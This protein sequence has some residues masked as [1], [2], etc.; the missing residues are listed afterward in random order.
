MKLDDML[1]KALSDF[2]EIAPIKS[3]RAS[4]VKCYR[5]IQLVEGVSLKLIIGI[6]SYFPYSLPHFFIEEYDSL[7][8]ML[9]HVETDGYVCFLEKDNILLDYENPEGIF[10]ESLDK[11][12]Q[13]LSASIQ[14][15]NKDEIRSEFISYWTLQP[16][17]LP[18][19]SFIEPSMSIKEIEGAFHPNSYLFY[20]NTAENIN[21]IEAIFGK[22]P[23]EQK[24]KVTYIPLRQNNNIYPPD[25][26]RGWS[27]RE[28][29]KIILGNLS[30][31]NRKLFNKYKSKPLKNPAIILIISIPITENNIVFIGVKLETDNRKKLYKNPLHKNVDNYKLTPIVIERY[32]DDYLIE[33]TSSDYS[34]KNKKVAIVGQGSL[35]S[36]VTMELARLGVRNLHLIDNDI[37]SID[38]IN[39]HELGMESLFGDGKA[40]SKVDA[41]T[42]ELLRKFPNIN[43]EVEELNVLDLL[44]GCPDYFDEF[45]FVIIAIGDTMTSLK[46]NNYF[47]YK[48][49][50]VIYSWLEPYGIGGHLLAV[51]YNNDGCYQCLYTS[52]KKDYL[53]SNRASLAEE[54]QDF[55]KNMASC[56]SRFIPYGSIAPLKASTNIIETFT[57]VVRKGIEKN[58]L[59]SWTG[60]TTLFLKEGFHLSNRYSIVSEQEKYKTTEFKVINCTICRS[61]K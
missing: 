57:E 52:P 20:D 47:K 39:R 2:E 9:P 35:G 59:L 13:L 58:F 41:M 30:G 12:L 55:N 54:G 49:I 33:R 24:F 32:D 1:A 19:K 61:R 60:D 45:D 3:I 10:F 34:F 15:I 25:Y 14:R 22:K 27:V 50:N 29:K 23:L 46:L 7:G 21:K 26:R 51:N 17:M 4:L 11:V 8:L 38:N 48:K 16:D 56:F 6:D 36:K 44:K 53:I 28:F 5:S 43:V 42:D 40:K 18:A 31:S 37:L